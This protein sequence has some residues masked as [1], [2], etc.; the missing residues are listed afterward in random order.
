[1]IHEYQIN[2]LQIKTGDLICTTD[3]GDSDIRC[4]FWRLVGKLIP[5]EVDHIV[6]YVGPKG[7]CVEAGAKGSVITF[8]MAGNTWDAEKME[9]AR[10]ALIDTFYGIA[11]PLADKGLTEL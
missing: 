10:G 11:Y 9:E 7:R 3:G 5:G 2:G 1:M 8:D 6:V 4:Q